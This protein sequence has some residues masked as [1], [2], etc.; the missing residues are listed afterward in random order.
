MIEGSPGSDPELF[1]SKPSATRFQILIRIIKHQPAINQNEIAEAVGLTPQ[2][3]SDYL[4]E[5]KTQGYVEKHGRGRY[6]VTKEGVNWILS[7]TKE[8]EKLVEYVDREILRDTEVE[9]AIAVEQIDEGQQV[10]L[11]M[12]ESKLHTVPGQAGPATA[13][14]VTNADEGGVVGVTSVDGMVEYDPGRVTVVTVPEVQNGGQNGVDSDRLTTQ[15][16]RHGRVAANGL[17]STVAA[18]AAGIEPDITLGVP[19][20]VSEAAMKGL[21]VLVLTTPVGITDIIEQLRQEDITH[22]MLDGTDL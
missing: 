21:D 5:L 13:V 8:L 20:S 6:E 2:S 1:T 11:S 9:S 16:Q 17:E 18:E 12:R 10:S 15:A 7:R 22:E 4:R 3:V 14:A 19:E